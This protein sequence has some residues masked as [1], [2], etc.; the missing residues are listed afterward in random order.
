M[1]MQISITNGQIVFDP[2]PAPDRDP[3]APRPMLAHRIEKA[4][5]P[6]RP[7]LQPK[8]DGVRAILTVDGL[9][10]RY[11]RKITSCPH[12]AL[13]EGCPALDGEIYLHGT[14]LESIAG[15]VRRI[16]PD[17]VS[18]S[19]EFHVFDLVDGAPAIDRQRRLDALP[20]ALPFVRVPTVYDASR[21]VAERH[22]LDC[23][24]RGF[25]GQMI[26]DPMAPY[27]PR[28]CNALL[29]RK[30]F[31]DL[32]CRIAS[33]STKDGRAVAATVI[34]PDGETFNVFL[35]ANH[36][37]RFSL[38]RNARAA[39]GCEATVRHWGRTRRGVP[40]HAVLHQMHDGMRAI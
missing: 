4:G 15:A 14:G 34:A 3:L 26:R 16:E 27:A 28:R 2:T 19:L 7:I 30:P 8:I 6:L 1:T 22:Y 32:D 33:I 36:A 24:A 20:M 9:F 18:L 17:A 11:G 21:A 29:K 12:I 31:D 38:A 40:R 13:P 37:Q 23:L 39:I 5:Y 10:T 35:K 25:E